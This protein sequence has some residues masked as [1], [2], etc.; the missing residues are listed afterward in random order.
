MAGREDR[1]VVV[2]LTSNSSVA[3]AVRG[4]LKGTPAS[5]GRV[6]GAARIVCTPEDGASLL[7]GEIVV[8]EAATPELT[9]LLALAA[10]VIAETGGALSSAAAVARERGVP[11]VVAA[12]DATRRIQ[13]G[14]IVTIDGAS[15]VVFF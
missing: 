13:D 6:T 14:Q 7:A 2:L 5:C 3:G 1:E 8:C 10:G 4:S 12:R 11:M 9:V 15:G